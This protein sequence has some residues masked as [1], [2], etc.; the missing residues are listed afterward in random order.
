MLTKRKNGIITKVG[1]LSALVLLS[2]VLYYAGTQ[3]RMVIAEDKTTTDCK[4]DGGC[5][6]GGGAPAGST[7]SGS[8]T[9]AAGTPDGGTVV[10]PPSRITDVGNSN[11]GG[12]CNACHYGTPTNQPP[13]HVVLPPS[14]G[15][16]A[17]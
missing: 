11:N 5:D 17:N 1:L 16:N 3:V 15:G 7:N 8:G 12:A 2:G 9:P 13:H 6:G 14:K 10:S 4:G